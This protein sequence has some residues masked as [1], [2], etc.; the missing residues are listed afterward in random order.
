MKTVKNFLYSIMVAMAIAVSFAL[1]GC[2]A[3]GYTVF[4]DVE[5]FSD[6]ILFSAKILG[7]RA[8]YAHTRM[9]NTIN[10][11]NKQ[12]S[13]TRADSDLCAFNNSG[14]NTPVQVGEHVY[15]LFN[16]AVEYYA[17]TDG[18]FNCAAAPLIEL[19]HV[20]A[21]ELSG[22]GT[23]ALPT[24]DEVLA[25]QEY[26]SPENIDAYTEGGKYYLTKTDQR[27]KLDFGGIAKGYAVDRCVEILGEYDVPSALLDISGNAYFYGK[28]VANG[29]QS[30]W[31]VGIMS[32]R[33]RSGET[34]SR[35]YVCAV[36]LS[37]DVSAVTSG[38]YMRYYVHTDSDGSSVYIPHILGTDG[39]PIGVEWADGQWKNS[40][41]WVISA[42]VIGDSSAECDALSTAVA[43]LGMEKGA[44]LLRKVGYKGLIFTEKRFTI[45][46]EVPMFD[47]AE[48]DGYKDYEYCEL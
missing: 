35:G 45:I 24:Q 39:V 15:N 4:Q 13:L 34:L 23:K 8:D 11:I 14:A 25:V 3:A 47:T 46:G 9:V 31:N 19:W 30:D 37:G 2:A 7:G 36:T 38:D 26:C 22:G 48:Y 5:A 41:E 21:G 43:S 17:L 10:D 32:P 6:D 12:T 44:Q 29:K 33:P 16:L 20:S 28:Y 40:A 42:T 1:G 18:A 27:I